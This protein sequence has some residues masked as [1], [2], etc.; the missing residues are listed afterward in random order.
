MHWS[1]AIGAEHRAARE[2][3]GAVRRVVVRQAGDRGTGRR[4]AA[5]AALRQPRRARGRADHLH[6][7][8]EPRA[9]GSNATS[10]SRA[11]TRSASRSSPAPRSASTTRAWIRRHLPGDGSV[12][13]DRR[14]L[15]L[16]LLRPVGPAGARRPR[17][18]D[19]RP[20]RLRL[21]AHAGADRR[22]RPGPGAAGHVRRRVRLGAL[23]PDRVRRRAVAGAVGGRAA[24]RAARRRLPRDRLA[25]AG[26]GLPR[27]GRGHHTR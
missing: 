9:A 12:D 11:S 22:R 5:R 15:A 6:A 27:V 19:A 7:D 20:A 14:D 26:E 24:A 4:R 8:A 18:A 3:R 23:L 1:P 25:A 13:A 16:G 10:P 17:A 2:T 21:H